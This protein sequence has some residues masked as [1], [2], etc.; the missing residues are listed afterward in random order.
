MNAHEQRKYDWLHQEARRVMALTAGCGHVG[1]VQCKERIKACLSDAER[2]K[3]GKLPA[4]VWIE[5]NVW[6]PRAVSELSRLATA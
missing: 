3:A 4:Y 2:L 1:T 6:R 5:S